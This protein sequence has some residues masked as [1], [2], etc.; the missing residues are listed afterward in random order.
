MYI[1]Y[2][3]WIINIYKFDWTCPKHSAESICLIFWTKFLNSN[4]YIFSILSII[5]AKENKKPAIKADSEEEEEEEEIEIPSSKSKTR[6]SN[7]SR[8]APKTDASDDDTS[9][10]ADEDETSSTTSSKKHKVRLFLTANRNPKHKKIK[11]FIRRLLNSS[12]T[13]HTY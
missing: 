10:K 11:T 9:T 7:S 4:I 3:I 6:I 12:K 8:K 5:K 13:G 1:G 2:H